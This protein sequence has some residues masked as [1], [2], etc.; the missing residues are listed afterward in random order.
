METLAMS[1]LPSQLTLGLSLKDE[2][3][4]DNFY[5]D[6]N[7]EIVSE[8]KKISGGVGERVIYLCGARVQGRSHLLQA[9]CHYAHQKQLSSVYLPLSHLLS[10]SPEMLNGLETLSLVCLDDLHVIAGIPAWEEA[11]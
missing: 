9:C 7:A 5:S 2:A 6:N 4:F 11:I 8:L 3:T 1:K 10:F